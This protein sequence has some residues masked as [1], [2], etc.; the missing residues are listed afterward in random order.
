MTFD[1]TPLA[2]QIDPS[3]DARK[4]AASFDTASE[5]EAQPG[6]TDIALLRA[7]RTDS[8]QFGVFYQRHVREVVRYC[9]ARTSSPE[10]AA[11]LTAEVFATAYVQRAKYRDEGRPAIAWLIGIARRQ[12][13][14]YYRRER[15]ATKYRK[16]LGL[17][18][19]DYT[20]DDLE[21]I[22]ELADSRRLRAL[23]TPSLDAL[24]DTIRMA[25]QLR[26]IDELSYEEVAVQLG[27][28]QGAARVRVSRGL[29]QLADALEQS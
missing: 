7:A 25:V 9:Y 28:S 16:R 23:A 5:R 6:L 3:I 4:F 8:V 13:G 10:V 24:P 26:V 14:T 19:I 27:C 11:D 20:N 21:R 18:A 22:E 12:L 17:T 29:S 15:V 2:N 1:G